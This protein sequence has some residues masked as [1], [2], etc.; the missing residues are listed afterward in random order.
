MHFTLYRKSPLGI[1]LENAVDELRQMG[2]ISDELK[3]DIMTQFDKSINEALSTIVKNKV[4]F[5][6]TKY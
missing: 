3:E 6:V 4:T 1:T 5:K 2:K